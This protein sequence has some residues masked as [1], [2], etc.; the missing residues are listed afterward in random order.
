[1]CIRDRAGDAAFIDQRIEFREVDA[2][3]KRADADFQRNGE[4]APALTC[5]LYTS[6]CV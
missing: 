2:G 5:L 3:G 6:R 1:M 4:P